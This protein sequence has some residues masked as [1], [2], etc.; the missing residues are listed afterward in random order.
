MPDVICLDIPAGARFVDRVRRAWDEGDSVFPLDGRLPAPARDAVLS[1]ARPTVIVTA[2]GERRVDG[3][4]CRDGDALLV[5]TS[6]TTGEPR[7]AVLTLDALRA[8]AEAV[9]G[10]LSIDA[11]DRWFACLPLA[12]VG[13][14]SVVA[15]S[16]LLGN[17][18][19]V[20]DRFSEEAYVAA[21]RSGCTRTSLVP[22][23]LSRVDPSMYRTIL[24]GGSA[25][26]AERPPHVVATYGMTET[27]GGVVYDGR[28]L[29]DVDV[30]VDAEGQILLRCPMLMRCYRDGGMPLSDG[31]DGSADWY[32]TGDLGEIASNGALSVH[33]RL[34]ERITTGG[35]KV[36]PNVV[37][38]ALRSHPAVADV[39]VA[40][41]D[42]PQW[43]QAVHAWVVPTPGERPSLQDVRAH[44][45]ESLPPW[46]APKV[47]HLIAEIPR[48]ALGKPR[49]AELASVVG[50]GRGDQ[51]GV[52]TG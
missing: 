41:V 37:E 4:P 3:E 16:L 44:V 28:A 31:P 43:G 21:A 47:L 11:G 14:F 18:V 46:C 9:A 33:G 20:V 22:A 6:G 8:S 35:E 38:N 34:G 19:D 12:H 52:S 51:S 42:D 17:D 49:R 2:E 45:K 39:C 50:E 32:P 29:E 30:A 15:R 5:A 10:R 40:G 24:L 23:T 48:T 1:A 26:P 25:P 7:V 36:W 13:G 27:G